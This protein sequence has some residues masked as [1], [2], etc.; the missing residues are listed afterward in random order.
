[1]GVMEWFVK[2]HIWRGCSYSYL[3]DLYW[4]NFFLI[5]LFSAIIVFVWSQYDGGNITHCTKGHKI[6][7]KKAN[8]DYF[9]HSAEL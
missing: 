1:M 2:T 7:A 3:I 5:F 8:G 6:K 4:D 9:V